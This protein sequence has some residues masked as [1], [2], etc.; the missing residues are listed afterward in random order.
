MKS[1]SK[2]LWAPPGFP[3][4]TERSLFWAALGLAQLWSLGFMV[5]FYNAR[6]SCY[7]W[8]GGKRSLLPDAVMPRFFELVGSAPEGF[9]LAAL[10]MAALILWHIHYYYQGSRSIYLMRRLPQ[11]GLLESSILL[12]PLCRAAVIL[13]AGAATLLVYALIYR[14]CCPPLCMPLRPWAL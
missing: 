4:D 9:V 3:V 2:L 14:F 6:E 13:L 8:Q 7:L 11:R 12:A 5:R 10:C 1:K